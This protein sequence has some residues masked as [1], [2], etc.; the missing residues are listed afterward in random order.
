MS[1]QASKAD[2]L[3]A[4][5]LIKDLINNGVSLSEQVSESR[6]V[7]ITYEFTQLAPPVETNRSPEF[8]EIGLA[9]SGES[10]VPQGSTA[11]HQ[12]DVGLGELI[13]APVMLFH[14]QSPSPCS[15]SSTTST[16]PWRTR[17]ITNRS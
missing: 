5:M 6:S 14:T 17:Q 15:N 4:I 13:A 1:D 12:K 7:E 2:V 10:D 3:Q 11:S 8:A 9:F 16:E